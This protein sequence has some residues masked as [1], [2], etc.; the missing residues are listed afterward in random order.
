[1]PKELLTFDEFQSMT[2]AL[3]EETPAPNLGKNA[4]IVFD[5]VYLKV[6]RDGSG[7]KESSL[8]RLVAVAVD[9]ASNTADYLPTGLS[10]TE[11]LAEVRKEAQ[12]YV[13]LFAQNLFR[14]NTPALINFGRWLP[15]FDK[16]GEL[17]GHRQRSQVGAGC[18]VIPIGDAFGSDT[19]DAIQSDTIP[20]AL[21]TQMLVQK[22]GG[23]TGFAFSDLRPEGSRIGYLPAVD[24]M[25]T[26]DWAS[27]KGVSS[28]PDSFLTKAFDSVSGAIKQGDS[29]RGANM[30]IQRIDH[31]DFL[32]HIYAKDPR[33]GEGHLVNFNLS[34]ALTDEFM[35]A[36]LSD[37]TYTLYVS[38]RADPDVKSMLERKFGAERPELMHKEDFATQAQFARILKMNQ[39]NPFTPRATPSMYLGDDNESVINAFTGDR[40]GTI[41]NGIVHIFAKKV[42]EEILV[43]QSFKN[44]EPGFVFLSLSLQQT[45]VVNSHFP[46]SVFVS[47]AR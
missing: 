42:L 40:I 44:G 2:S 33:R 11:V 9:I 38:Q 13:S 20:G 35:E 27:L 47:L 16:R 12:E 8:E 37:R 4:Q 24:G 21:V 22:G 46:P 43:A 28:G 29:R 30:G 19:S 32:K 36:A 45:L 7:K 39:D 5:D 25:E 23:G 41:H 1:M 15:V 10:R 17:I 31:P 6:A 3:V 26:F 14:P 34:L 18:F